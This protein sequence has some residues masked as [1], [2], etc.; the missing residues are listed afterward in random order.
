MEAKRCLKERD[1][2][3]VPVPNEMRYLIVIPTYNEAENIRILVPNVLGLG[4][5]FHVLVVDDNSPDGTADVVKEIGQQDHRLFLIQRTA[6]MG[7][8]SA[9]IAGFQYA[10]QWGADYVFEMDADHSHD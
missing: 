10:L 7:L 3:I 9:Y 6:K 1:E 2:L 5:E 4:K 8:G